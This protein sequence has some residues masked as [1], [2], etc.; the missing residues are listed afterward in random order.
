MTPSA[1]SVCGYMPR[2][3]GDDDAGYALGVLIGTVANVIDPQKV[4]L[5]GEG[6][7]LYEVSSR[8]VHDGIG[9]TYED[10]PDLIEL[11]VQPFD[12]REWARSGAALA[13]KDTITGSICEQPSAAPRRVGRR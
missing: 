12:F 5:T 10:D 2:G 4:L 6:L 13:I 7:P 3:R 11:E 8:F 1:A 9:D